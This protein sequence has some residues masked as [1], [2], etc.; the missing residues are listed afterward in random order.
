MRSRK[1][2]IPDSL[3]YVKT[4]VAK[5]IAE[6]EVLNV[7]SERKNSSVIKQKI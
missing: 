6:K 3:E 2:I 7:P 5:K 4:I 1:A